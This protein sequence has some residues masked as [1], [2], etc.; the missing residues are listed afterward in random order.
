MA[1]LREFSSMYYNPKK[2]PDISKLCC[3]PYNKIDSSKKKELYD[4]DPYNY[5]N[6]VLPEGDSQEKYRNS[7]KRIFSWLLRDV[8]L[9]DEKPSMYL[10]EHNFKMDGVNQVRYGITTLVKL[11]EDPQKIKISER[12]HSQGVEDRYNLL[13]ETETH[14]E[15]VLFACNDSQNQLLALL[16]QIPEK[17]TVMQEVKDQYANIHRI[18]RIEDESIVN[19]IKSFTGDKTFYLLEGVHKYQA[20]LQYRK[21]VANAPQ[22][23]DG[24]RSDDYILGTIV[25]MQDT[26]LKTLP[27]NVNLRET[28]MSGVAFLKGLEKNFKMGAMAFED[29]RM[30][31]A[32]RVKLRKM[33]MENKARGILSL[34]VYIKE[35]PGKYFILSV[36]PEALT[37]IKAGIG[38]SEIKKSQDIFYWE[39]LIIQDALKLKMEDENKISMVRGDNTALEAVKSG[40][41]DIALIINPIKV[42]DVIRI[43]DNNEQIPHLSADFYPSLLGGLLAYSLKYSK[44]KG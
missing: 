25:V 4:S 39:K 26:T 8:M 30:E 27:A 24:T 6:L 3:P 44:I 41:F 37:Q 17:S 33:M 12:S 42:M 22:V 29:E 11:E 1:Q 7:I 2:N 9:I 10:Y 43:A 28:G 31:R 38:G 36:T 40:E 23:I 19:N 35:V 32:A 15:S 18:Y 16:K 20:A 21:S 5:V 34:G 14:L 13:K